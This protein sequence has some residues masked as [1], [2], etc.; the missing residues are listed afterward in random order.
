MAVG[1]V[2]GDVGGEAFFAIEDGAGDVHVWCFEAGGEGDV[3]G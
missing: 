1:E 2:G 3:E